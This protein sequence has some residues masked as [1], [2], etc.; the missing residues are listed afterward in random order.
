MGVCCG[1]S[2]GTVAQRRCNV[3]LGCRLDNRPPVKPTRRVDAQ[4][5]AYA[6]RVELGPDVIVDE[7]LMYGLAKN[8]PRLTSIALPG[9]IQLTTV[10][11]C[12]ALHGKMVRG[13]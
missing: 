12:V 4:D 9:C 13:C 1:V 11:A 7:R 10:R 8:C 3:M 6:E 2:R 5:Y